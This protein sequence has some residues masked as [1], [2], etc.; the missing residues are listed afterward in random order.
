M[1]TEEDWGTAEALRRVMI[2]G[3]F[4]LGS[5]VPDYYLPDVEGN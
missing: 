4:G 5:P 3:T 1:Q 2:E